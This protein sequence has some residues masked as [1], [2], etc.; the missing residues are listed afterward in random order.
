MAS[1]LF[2]CYSPAGEKFELTRPNYLDAT[3]NFG[4]TTTPP[5]TAPAAAD[6]DEIDDLDDEEQDE[7]DEQP[8]DETPADESDE[9]EADEPVEV[10]APVTEAPAADEAP[11]FD[12]NDRDS[13][14][15]FLRKNE[16]EFDG[17]A[18]LADLVALANGKSA[19]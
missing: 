12:P 7:Q 15:T 19:E 5:G 10:E 14:K 4:F 6:E 13:V 3:S 2:T 9:T 8:A 1:N 16:I 17:R 18:S 11:A